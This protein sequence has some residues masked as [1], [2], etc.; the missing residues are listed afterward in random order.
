[1]KQGKK[2]YRWEGLLYRDYKRIMEG[3]DL[4]SYEA[5]SEKPPGV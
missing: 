2:G 3:P 5:C 4:E 1:M